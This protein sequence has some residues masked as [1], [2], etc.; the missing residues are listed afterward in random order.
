MK[1]ELVHPSCVRLGG[2]RPDTLAIDVALSM[3]EETHR[4]YGELRASAMCDACG[5]QMERGDQAVAQ[6]FVGIG[7]S[8]YP[9]ES[10]Y[11][12]IEGTGRRNPKGGE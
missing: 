6:T 4:V 10:D 11:L 5:G 1:R 9:W 8:Y 3:G 2:V 7:Q 12:C